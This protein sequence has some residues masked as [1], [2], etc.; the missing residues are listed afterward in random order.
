MGEMDERK[1]L[2]I[3][4][5]IL[6]YNRPK[7]LRE[8]LLSVLSQTREPA[9]VVILDNGS[10][11]GTRNAVE[12]LI[13][14]RVSFIG[15]ETT[16]PPLWNFHRA[17]AMAKRKYLTV[18]HDDDRL[19]PRF[20]EETVGLL[21]SDDEL[22]AVSTDGHRIDGGGRRLEEH[23]LPDSP[24]GVLYFKNE[25]EL[26]MRIAESSM[27]FPNT[28]YRNGYPQR[29]ANRDE[30]GKISDCIFLLDMAR[31]GKMAIIGKPLYEYRIHSGQDSV[32]FPERLLQ[33]KEDFIIGLFD[34]RPEQK[35]VI[36]KI[37]RKQSRRFIGLMLVSV[38]KR[39]DPAWFFDEFQGCKNH[40]V[41]LRYIFYYTLL[42]IYIRIRPRDWTVKSDD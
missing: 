28:V 16:H 6:S 5:F 4:V 8:M 1:Q 27:A 10:D 17:M 23:L 26:G 19:T 14:G 35:E 22:I 38:F 42:N 37:S 2:D 34:G 18:V 11:N 36:T 7:Y 21:E 12:D 3:T 9:E 40:Y 41:K 15:A 31:L 30:F 25:R 33:L 39:R 13:G 24:A 20:L 29:V 32:H